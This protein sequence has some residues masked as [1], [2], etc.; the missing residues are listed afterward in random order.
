M[1]EALT[2]AYSSVYRGSVS[3][4]SPEWHIGGD[5]NPF[6][7]YKVLANLFMEAIRVDRQFCEL[8]AAI[9]CCSLDY[10]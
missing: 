5:F 9:R 4:Y 1:Y 6:G 2:A 7:E 8:S 10:N 3:P